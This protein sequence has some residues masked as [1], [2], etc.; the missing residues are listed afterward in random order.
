MMDAFLDDFL[1]NAKGYYIY[2][3]NLGSFDGYFLLKDLNKRCESINILMDANRRFISIDIKQ[4]KTRFRDSLRI[5]PASLDSLSKM[6]N[7]DIKKGF[8]DHSKVNKALLMSDSFKLEALEYL[9]RDLISLLDVLVKAN[10]YLLNEYSIDFT[11]CYSAS[12]MAMKIYRT[13]FMTS[14]IPLLPPHIDHSVRLSYRGGATEVYKCTGNNLYY[15]DI[16]SLYP[17]AMLSPMPF[18][19]LGVK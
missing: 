19:F 11:K 8:L 13:Q 12:S 6:F 4:S 10:E 2:C 15:Y 5:L 18:K 9:D 14:P 1:A 7:V 16:N 17:Y 3:H